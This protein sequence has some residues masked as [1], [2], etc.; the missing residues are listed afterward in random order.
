ML[1]ASERQ[2]LLTLHLQ[3]RPVRMELDLL[4]KAALNLQT[5]PTGRL[6]RPYVNC[7]KPGRTTPMHAMCKNLPVCARGLD[8]WL[9]RPVCQRQPDWVNREFVVTNNNPL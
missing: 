7:S 3:L 5:N 4:A 8:G 6:P 2:E 1:T 9:D